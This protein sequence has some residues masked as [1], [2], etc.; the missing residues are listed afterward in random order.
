MYYVPSAVL[1]LLHTLFYLILTTT[2][3]SRYYSSVLQKRVERLG[4]WLKVTQLISARARN[5]IQVIL[6]LEPVILTVA[7]NCY[8]VLICRISV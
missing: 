1:K 8:G 7:I 5:Q 6:S 4:N 3:G 2:L